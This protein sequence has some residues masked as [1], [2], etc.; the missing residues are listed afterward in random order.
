MLVAFTKAKEPVWISFIRNGCGSS[1]EIKT[2]LWRSATG[3]SKQLEVCQHRVDNDTLAIEISETT[4]WLVVAHHIWQKYFGKPTGRNYRTS[5][6]KTL[7]RARTCQDCLK[8]RRQSTLLSVEAFGAAFGDFLNPDL[9]D[10]E[11]ALKRMSV[12]LR[13]MADMDE[14]EMIDFLKDIRADEKSLRSA[15][16]FLMKI[17]NATMGNPFWR[18]LKGTD[19]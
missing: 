6:V 8:S 18:S 14:N 2:E 5:S 16:P 15:A 11:K 17:K 10:D 12:V 7:S 4:N 19:V 13:R 1:S 9:E 3:T